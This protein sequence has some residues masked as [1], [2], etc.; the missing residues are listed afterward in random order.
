MLIVSDTS[1]LNYLICIGVQDVLAHLY[2][3]ILVPSQVIEEPRREKAPAQVRAWVSMLPAWVK[4]QDGDASRFPTLDH[5]EAAALD[6]AVEIHADA[7]LADDAEARMMAKTVGITAI[8]TLGILTEAHNASLLDF[9]TA[10]NALRAT[11]FHLH[12]GAIAAVRTRIRAPKPDGGH[13]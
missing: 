12:E 8:G 9:D 10:I 3:T 4:V 2:E 1:P 7:L 11:S 5:G 6:L 13:Q